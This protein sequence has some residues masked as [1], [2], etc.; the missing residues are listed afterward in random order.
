MRKL[1]SLCI[2]VTIT[3]NATTWASQPPKDSPQGV[4]GAQL[5]WKQK[6]M[7]AHS[8]REKDPA[9]EAR[10][11][12]MRASLQNKPGQAQQPQNDSSKEGKSSCCSMM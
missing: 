4:A 2:C 5:T 8:R 6:R 1:F 11:A 3:L 7:Q 12:A 10:R 9:L